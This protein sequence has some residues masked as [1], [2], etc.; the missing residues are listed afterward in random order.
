MVPYNMHSMNLYKLVICLFLLPGFTGFAQDVMPEKFNLGTIATNTEIA[1]WDTDIKPD[2]TG[3]PAGGGTVPLGEQLFIV[4]CLMCHGPQGKNGPNPQLVGRRPNDA[5]DFG[6][7]HT[8][9]RTVGNYWPYATTLFD[10]I[11]RAMPQVEPG[12]LKPEEVYSLTAYIL[13]LN[14]IIPKDAV[15]NATTLPNIKMPAKD[16]F[17]ID[18]N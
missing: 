3:L 15:L 14:E 7:D 2:G 10:Y 9:A 8:I 6:N 18:D 13:Y 17:Y 5:F 4:K 1:L 16:R 11:W 12:S